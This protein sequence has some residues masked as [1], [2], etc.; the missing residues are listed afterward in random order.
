MRKSLGVE[1]AA[2]HIRVEFMSLSML[3]LAE[4]ASDATSRR[5]FREMF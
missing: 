3:S 1:Y 2:R 5:K 4:E